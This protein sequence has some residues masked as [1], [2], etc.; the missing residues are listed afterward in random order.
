MLLTEENQPPTISL[1]KVDLRG[2]PAQTVILHEIARA[3]LDYAAKQRDY[4]WGQVS[5]HMASDV[6][7][8]WAASEALTPLA[9]ARDNAYAALN[10]ALRWVA[11]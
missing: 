7:A 9:L 2:A 5:L 3:A 10:A 11:P 4:A 6:E 8:Y 1:S